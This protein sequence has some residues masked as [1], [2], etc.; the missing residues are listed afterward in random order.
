MGSSGSTNGYVIPPTP[1][2]TGTNES[3]PR[4]NQ[5]YSTKTIKEISPDKYKNKETSSL[6]SHILD[7]LGLRKKIK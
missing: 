2:Y 3:H 6:L 5:E 1:K 4:Y 7:C